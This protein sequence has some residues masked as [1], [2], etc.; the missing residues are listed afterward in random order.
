[1]ILREGEAQTP[2]DNT[3]YY[4]NVAAA[5]VRGKLAPAAL[6]A[7]LQA[8]PPEGLSRA[9]K[10][11]LFS[12]GKRRGLQLHKFKRNAT[13]P[14][15]RKVLGM[16]QSIYPQRLLDI[17][18]GRGV[19]LW[20][21]IDAFPHLCVTATDI[22]THRVEDMAAVGRGGGYPLTACLADAACL[23]FGDKTFDMVTALEVLEHIRTV[24]QAVKEICRVS[25]RFVIISV[26]S[27]PDRNPEHLHLLEKA[28]L[29]ALFL[30]N[31]AAGIAFSHVLNHLIGI[32][33]MV[34]T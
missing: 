20:P 5:F 12:I 11:R 23:G 3:A 33:K 27:K 24:D 30:N 9:G 10:E 8:D 34:N 18:S 1:M 26:P 32:A 19:F 17:G 25:R 14:R 29:E 22:L 21:L 13:L 28:E 7:G 16:V 2:M 6:T 4:L 31:G 15:I